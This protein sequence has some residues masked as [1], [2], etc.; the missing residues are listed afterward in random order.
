V[1]A[2][3]EGVRLLGEADSGAWCAEDADG[4]DDG[5]DCGDREGVVL[6]QPSGRHP[7]LRLEAFGW[8]DDHEKARVCTGAGGMA[9]EFMGAASDCAHPPPFA[10]V[11]SDARLG[12]RTM[13]ELLS[14]LGDS[15]LTR[16]GR[17]GACWQA[18]LPGDIALFGD[19]DLD[20]V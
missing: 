10:A 18:R 14:R 2:R 16:T 7:R 12:M 8:S 5:D 3:G 19:K 20:K 1:H 9:A 17:P 13:P 11:T 4:G 15:D 6:C